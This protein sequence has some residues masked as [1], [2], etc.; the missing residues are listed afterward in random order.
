MYRSLSDFCITLET[1][2]QLSD[3]CFL[4]KKAK[5]SY[6]DLQLLLDKSEDPAVSARLLGGRNE[7]LLL[8][9]FK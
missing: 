9:I 2:R 4:K 1:Q 7:L 8:M 6:S 5:V 3:E